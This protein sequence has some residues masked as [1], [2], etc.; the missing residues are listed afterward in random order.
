MSIAG[1]AILS[2]I[3]RLWPSYKRE[4]VFPEQQLL[5]SISHAV[6]SWTMLGAASSCCLCLE[7]VL[8]SINQMYKC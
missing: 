5:P 4:Q 1:K 8:F 6:K 2:K 3:S 7:I